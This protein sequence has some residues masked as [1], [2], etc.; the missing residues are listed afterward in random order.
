MILNSILK[1]I[2][3]DEDLLN[4][5]DP[6]H[7]MALHYRPGSIIEL[8]NPIHRQKKHRDRSCSHRTPHG[9]FLFDHPKDTGNII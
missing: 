6:L 3:L 5:L 7:Q 4:A 1:G 9:R 2:D 8:R